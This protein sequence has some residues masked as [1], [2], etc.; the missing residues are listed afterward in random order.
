MEQHIQYTE[1]GRVL[2]HG[3]EGTFGKQYIGFAKCK[4]RL[5]R[6][7]R[8]SD[9]ALM[10]P[11]DRKIRVA[12]GEHVY[13]TSDGNYPSLTHVVHI[14]RVANSSPVGSIHWHS[15]GISQDAER[16]ITKAITRPKPGSLHALESNGL[17][18]Y[19][20]AV[21]KALKRYRCGRIKAREFPVKEG[22]L[23]TLDELSWFCSERTGMYT[24]IN[25]TVYELTGEYHV[26]LGKGFV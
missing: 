7:Y 19:S 22:P 15:Y 25:G 24:A 6:W 14:G 16:A 8:E 17:G 21:Q 2:K 18:E 23:Y 12:I 11:K 4:G 1:H 3:L 13:S 5:K 20:W 9:L 26:V 10:G